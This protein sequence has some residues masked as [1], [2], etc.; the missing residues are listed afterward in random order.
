M[1]IKNPNKDVV[2]NEDLVKRIERTINGSKIMLFM[3]GNKTMPMCGFSGRVLSILNNHGVDY[4]TYDI[5]QDQEL[6]EGIKIY[7]NWPTFPQLY[8]NSELIGGCDIVV[9]MHESGEL[10]EVLK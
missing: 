5:L 3:K 10:A 9:E 7:S 6:R 2:L 4:E 1:H 8:V